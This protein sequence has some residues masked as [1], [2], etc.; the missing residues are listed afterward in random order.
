MG[1]GKKICVLRVSWRELA[2]ILA[3]LRFHQAQNLQGGR[4][5]PDQSIKGIAAD[6]GAFKPLSFKA[7][8]KLCERLNTEEDLEVP[9]GLVVEPPHKESGD[10]PLLRVVYVIDVNAADCRKAAEGVHQIMMDM[11][12]CDGQPPILE[13]INH[14]G[15][16]VSIDLSKG[17]PP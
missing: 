7:V 4:D 13:V 9:R 14:R 6:G 17:S 5:I 10:E 16:V 1:R 3:A 2:T 12:R 11:I 8:E 15:T